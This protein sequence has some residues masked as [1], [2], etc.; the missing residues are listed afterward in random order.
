VTTARPGPGAAYFDEAAETRSRADIEAM[1]LERLMFMLPHTYEHSALVRAVWEQAG[2]HPRDIA[3]LDD[4]FER[5]PFIDKAAIDR[6]RTDKGDPWGGLLCLPDSE[7]TT[8]L[9]SSG[10][11]GEPTLSPQRWAASNGPIPAGLSRDLWMM[12]IRPGDFMMMV[13]FTFRGP[14]FGM[15]QS[16]GAVPV[17]VDYDADDMLR[18]CELSLRY[19]P[20]GL[21]NLSSVIVL[22]MA[23]ACER[24]GY[25]PADVFA[26]YRAVVQAGEPL[27]AKARA[28]VA[29]WGAPMF[30]HTNVG[31]VGTAFQCREHDG[32]HFWEDDT[33][34]ETLDPSGTKPVAD[35]ERGEL[36][37]TSLVNPTTPLIRY[38][39]DDIV[40]MTRAVCACGRTHA[41]IWPVGRKGDGVVVDGR[42]ILPI[43]VWAAVESVD[44]CDLG[45][46]QVIREAPAMDRLRL[47]VGHHAPD[48]RLDAVRD[49][50]TNAVSLRLGV[51]PDIELVPDAALLV[52]GPPHKIP[53]VTAR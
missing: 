27:S 10:T 52:L 3:S 25:D 19:R 23:D 41:R 32:L 21:Y 28:V 49:E 11:T 48:A 44:A 6:W 4:Y 38:R 29:S 13:I 22:A 2:V 14:A 17:L 12:G 46:F 42:T 8:I 37:A 43:D 1:Q 5:A 26:S 40:R 16:F 34:A 31:D 47:R 33:L 36:V 30:E 45:L 20:T 9:S 15:A 51:T 35:H 50:V 18:F 24:G 53:R 7:L 39:S